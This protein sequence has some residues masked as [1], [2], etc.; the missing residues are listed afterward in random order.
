MWLVSCVYGSTSTSAVVVGLRPYT[1]FRFAIR[2]HAGSLFGP[3]GNEIRCRTAEGREYYVALFYDVLCFPQLPPVP[4]HYWLSGR[5]GILPVKTEWWDAG[6]VICLQRG[7]DL[8]MAQLMPLPLPL[9]VSC[10]S[11]I[12]IGFTFLV[13]ADMG[14][15]RKKGP[16]N[17]CMFVCVCL[18]VCVVFSADNISPQC[19]LVIHFVLHGFSCFFTCF[20][21]LYLDTFLLL[22]PALCKVQAAIFNR[23]AYGP[24]D[25]TAT[26]VWFYFS[27][28]GSP[29]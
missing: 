3:F 9:T 20:T 28:T 19:S 29:G 13:L 5:K 7:A 4:W 26:L 23:L 24:A 11:K 2:S 1:F 16:L 17:W 25:A 10:F 18:C 12:Q 27:G 21:I 14:S 15:P 6:V 22:L 8:H